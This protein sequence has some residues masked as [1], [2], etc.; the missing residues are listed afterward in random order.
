MGH[1]LLLSI[2]GLKTRFD[3]REAGFSRSETRATVAKLRWEHL[4]QAAKMAGPEVAAAWAAAPP[5][6]EEGVVG[7]PGDHPFLE[8]LTA[9]L[10]SD[11]GKALIAALIALLMAI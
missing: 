9:F 10:N 1:R 2:V 4:G 11:L 8:W 3:M 7:A 5:M 6:P